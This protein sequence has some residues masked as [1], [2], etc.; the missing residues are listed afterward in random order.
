VAHEVG[1]GACEA[2]V[3]LKLEAGNAVCPRK[4]VAHGSDASVWW[5]GVLGAVAAM[6]LC[7]GECTRGA[8]L[9]GLSKAFDTRRTQRLA[10]PAAADLAEAR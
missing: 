6:G 4:G 9:H 1:Q 8:A 3:G 7:E 2:G 5:A 10:G